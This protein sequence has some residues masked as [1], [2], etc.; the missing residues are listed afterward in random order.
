MPAGRPRKFDDAKALDAAIGVFWKH[1]Y[2]GAS[3]DLLTR[4]MGINRPS[5]YGAFGDK[6]ELFAKAVRRYQDQRF[7]PLRQAFADAPNLEA[8]IA[9]YF[10]AVRQLVAGRGTPRGCLTACVLVEASEADPR[11]RAMSEEFAAAGRSALV[12]ALGAY[13][14]KKA[15]QRLAS[16]LTVCTPGLAALARAGASPAELSAAIDAATAACLALGTKH[17]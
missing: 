13:V 6:A 3:L 14:P 4:A 1:G 10:A 15:A 5:L 8:G 2:E 7:L 12:A 9:A 16:L 17:A 11:W